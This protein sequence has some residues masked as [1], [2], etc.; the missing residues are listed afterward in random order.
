M[1]ILIVEYV[2]GGGF[3]PACGSHWNSPTS[4]GDLGLDLLSEG[5]AML[6][7]IVEDCLQSSESLQVHILRDCRFEL[8]KTSRCQQHTIRSREEWDETL[9]RLSQ[10]A[11]GVILIAP[12]TDGVLGEL[13]K[14]MESWGAKLLSPSASFCQWA[15]DKHACARMLQVHGIP[16]PAGCS[17]QEFIDGFRP[18][19][20]DFPCVVKPFDGAGSQRIVCM[21]SSDQLLQSVANEQIR[22]TDRVETYVPGVPAS[23][24]ILCQEDGLVLPLVPCLQHLTHDGSFRYLGGELVTKSELVERAKRLIESC[25]PVLRTARGY[26]GLDFVYG[27]A[28]DGRDDVVIE[29][30]PRLTTSYVGLRQRAQR[31]LAAWMLSSILGEMAEMPRFDTTPC[32][33]RSNGELVN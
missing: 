23:I 13:A 18:T 28:D 26:V 22:L 7:A 17:V 31:N 19:N 25:L 21:R 2:T 9:Y 8:M 5:R 1:E 32:I 33:F 30:N 24:S 20:I 29:I 3:L 10:L 14:L 4:I 15:S 12:E 16:V 27:R 11:A 6:H